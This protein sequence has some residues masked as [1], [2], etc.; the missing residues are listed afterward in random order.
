[1]GKS[2]ELC[3]LK[4][5][6]S[7]CQENKGRTRTAAALEKS[8]MNS[9]EHLDPA[10]RFAFGKNWACFLEHLN[11]DCIAEAE[12]SLSSMLGLTNLQGDILGYWVW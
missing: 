3:Y 7:W 8:L 4:L 10:E 1:L 12:K 11:D 9:T 6:K 5:K 2:Q